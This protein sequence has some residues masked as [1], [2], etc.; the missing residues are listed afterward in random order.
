MVVR[1]CRQVGA[2][3]TAYSEAI[4]EATASLDAGINATEGSAG[5]AWRTALHAFGR[6]VSTLP[7]DNDCLLRTSECSSQLLVA[8]QQQLTRVMALQSAQQRACAAAL[9]THARAKAAYVEASASANAESMRP[10]ARDPW[11]GELKLREAAQELHEVR[12]EWMDA[13]GNAWRE[14]ELFEAEQTETLRGALLQLVAGWQKRLQDAN[15]ASAAAAELLSWMDPAMEWTAFAQAS[16][17]ELQH[18]VAETPPAESANM[19]Q[20]EKMGTL[21]QRESRLLSTQ[22]TWVAQTAVVTRSGFLHLFAFSESNSS[23]QHSLPLLGCS[24]TRD[25][26]EC[27]LVVPPQGMFGVTLRFVFRANSEAEMR[28][29]TA[30][31]RRHTAMLARGVVVGGGGSSGGAG[32]ALPGGESV[33]GLKCGNAE[34]GGA[35]ASDE[36][37]GDEKAGGVEADGVEACGAEVG[38]AEVRGQEAIVQSGASRRQVGGVAVV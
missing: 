17:S 11:L 18:C 2:A 31:L 30:V 38:G 28:S 37:A 13:V 23:P 7:S 14:H 15:Q 29:W 33:R 21:Q 27:T 5:G 12:S 16:C 8:A 10:L 3:H 6:A 32:G 34:T 19:A 35:Q 4:A 25:T 36:E 24:L 9:E 26:S 22:H 20:V 1:F